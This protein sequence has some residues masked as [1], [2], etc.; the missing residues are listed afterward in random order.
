MAITLHSG[1][2]IGPGTVLDAGYTPPPLPPPLTLVSTN[3]LFNLDM[4]NYVTGIS[5]PDASSN[6]NNFIFSGTPV[7]VNQG[8]NQAYWDN[9]Y[10]LVADPA[11]GKFEESICLVD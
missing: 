5:W 7:V 2:T 10:M 9:T 11:G 6:H 3:L 8:T 1:F 4:Q